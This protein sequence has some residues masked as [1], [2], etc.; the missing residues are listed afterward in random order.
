MEQDIQLVRGAALATA[1]RLTG[2]PSR[3][4][5]GES[6]DKQEASHRSMIARQGST[7]PIVR[8]VRQD[9]QPEPPGVDL[10]NTP[11]E[12]A[13]SGWQSTPAANAR[14]VAVEPTDDFDGCYVT[15]QT[16]GHPGFHDHDIA[17]VV[18]APNGKW[19]TAGSTGA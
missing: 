1:R 3:Q 10:F 13:L 14:V 12:A 5:S 9:A 7:T 8:G 16:D 15:V 2:A 11:E 17:S 4:E 18:R 6:C 19:W